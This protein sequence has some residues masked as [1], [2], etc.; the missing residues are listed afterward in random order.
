MPE[1]IDPPV[2]PNAPRLH[3]DPLIHALLAAREVSREAVGDFL[4]PK[5][6]Q[7]PNPSLLPGMDEAVV[8]VRAA[9]D[10]RETVALYGDYD[11]DGV[12]SAAIVTLALGAASGGAIPA[13][14][15]LPTRQDGYGLNRAAIDRF[16]AQG[17]TLLLV[18]DCGSS[19]NEHVAYAQS[20]GM[21]VVIL[22]HHE[23]H[24][25]GPEG[26]IVGSA[27]LQP[28]NVYRHLPAAGLCLLM[29]T[30]LARAGYDVGR[31]PGEDP[32]HLIDLTM[33]AVI[34][35]VCD[36][37]DPVTRAMVRDG[38]RLVRTSPRPGLLALARALK[39]DPREIDSRTIGFRIAPPLNAAG[40]QSSAEPSLNLLLA[41]SEERGS[42]HVSAVLASLEWVRQQRGALRERLMT[43]LRADPAWRSHPIL[44]FEAADCP[45]GIAGTLAGDLVKEVGRPV[46]VLTRDGEIWRGSARS[47]GD[48]DIGGALRE[49]AG[50]L[51]RTGGHRAAA[52]LSVHE[53]RLAELRDLLDAIAVGKGYQPSDGGEL[54]IHADLPVDRITLATLSA[55]DRLRPWGQGNPEPTLRVQRAPIR[56]VYTMGADKT[57]LKLLLETP[58]GD[59]SA[60][61]WGQAERESEA[62]S[63]RHVDVAGVLKK[64]SY[65]GRDSAQ[66][67]C[68]DFRAAR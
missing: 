21:D 68:E 32:T 7:L 40:R 63:L 38:L 58:N 61:L 67:I 8:R 46:I 43:D 28:G 25:P 66:L 60:I 30:A 47:H 56:N 41:Q 50:L 24:G 12:C 6:R 52:G 45:H 17:A 16:H 42:P 2:V 18:V 37:R 62:R 51:V 19:D 9:I 33:V 26:A 20:K 22:D 39:L 53:S 55:I 4:D 64:N 59:V 11:A 23:M 13:I 29:A 48:F 49:A 5:S 3:D 65:N 44:L 36:L 10:Q 1:W 57:H 35:D 14:T 27:R 31:G 34:S 54:V 15:A